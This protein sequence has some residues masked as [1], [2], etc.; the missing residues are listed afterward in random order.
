[1]RQSAK[2]LTER[3]KSGCYIHGL[4]LEGAR[5]NHEKHELGESR[6]KELYTDMP[7]MWLK[8]K[9]NRIA[10]DSGFYECPVYKTL[11]RAG[12]FREMYYEVHFCDTSTLA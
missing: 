9:E 12:K 7:V 8:P 6:P 3:P 10:P 4:F 11:Q 2:S 1:M 5:W